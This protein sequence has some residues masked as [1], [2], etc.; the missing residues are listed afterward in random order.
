MIFNEVK[1]FFAYQNY[2]TIAKVCLSLL[3]ISLENQMESKSNGYDSDPS[4]P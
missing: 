2:S 3:D 4:T 1:I